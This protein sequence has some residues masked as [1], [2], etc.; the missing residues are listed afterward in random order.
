MF[1]GRPPVQG[2]VEECP[3]PRV[4]Q[5]VLVSD[6]R[7]S[8]S[9]DLVQRPAETTLSYGVD[10]NHSDH[11]GIVWKLLK[12]H[13]NLQYDLFSVGYAKPF[14]RAGIF[15][16]IRYVYNISF[17][18]F[19]VLYIVHHFAIWTIW[20]E[21]YDIITAQLTEFQAQ[22]NE[23]FRSER[24]IIIHGQDGWVQ[25]AQRTQF[26]QLGNCGC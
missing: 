18:S 13:E 25:V 15:N 17:K 4:P 9:A 11:S 12:F 16:Y 22:R 19:L 3:D 6:S 20:F 2:H 10:M 7:H 1:T 8:Y 26:Q 21:Y 5:R 23:G 24:V 14:A